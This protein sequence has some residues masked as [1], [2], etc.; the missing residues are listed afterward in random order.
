M[1]I[2]QEF[3]KLKHA[4]D[5]ILNEASDPEDPNN[6]VPT[7][8]KPLLCVTKLLHAMRRD[9]PG[10]LQKA[11]SGVVTKVGELERNLN[12]VERYLDRFSN[13]I[14]PQVRGELETIGN[15]TAQ[16]GSRV[17]QAEQEMRKSREVLE[18]FIPLIAL[19]APPPTRDRRF[20][21][22]AHL[23]VR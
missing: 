19:E 8:Y 17:D 7:E 9:P 15:K 3:D 2:E 1:P 5:Y 22:R 18:G 13:N 21:S 23:R 11:I 6:D 4:L 16:L 20:L 14:L 10:E 12:G